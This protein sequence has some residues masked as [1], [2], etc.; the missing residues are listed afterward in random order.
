MCILGVLAGVNRVYFSP[1]QFKRTRRF[2]ARMKVAPPDLAE[3]LDGLF[4][5]QVED[6]IGG[7]EQLVAETLEVVRR[8]VP[9]ANLGALRRQ[10]GER[11]QPW[12]R[13]Q[14]RPGAEALEA[15]VARD[16][17]AAG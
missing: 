8:E 10:P 14:T 5:A 16:R 11:Q 13:G 15:A 4:D 9:D 2:V 12:A 6:A 17:P 1:V 3:R 7:A